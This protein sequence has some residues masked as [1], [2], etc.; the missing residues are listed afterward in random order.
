MWYR[1]ALAIGRAEGTIQCT[2]AIIYN[3]SGK[4]LFALQRR[5]FEDQVAYVESNQIRDDLIVVDTQTYGA[6]GIIAWQADARTPD[7]FVDTGYIRFDLPLVIANEYS[8]DKLVPVKL[9]Y[10]AIAYIKR[11][12]STAKKYKG[13][14]NP[15]WLELSKMLNDTDIFYVKPAAFDWRPLDVS[16]MRNSSNAEWV[17]KVNKAKKEYEQAKAIMAAASAT[18]LM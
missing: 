9:D 7:G 16:H 15:R 3:A 1:Q 2:Y 12:L 5:N 4:K 6:E 14:Y 10:N 17:A 18:V 8:Q 11:T 13:G